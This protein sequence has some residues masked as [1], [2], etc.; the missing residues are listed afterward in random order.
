MKVVTSI[1]Q[2]LPATL[3][4]IASFALALVAEWGLLSVIVRAMAPNRRS[5]MKEPLESQRLYR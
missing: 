1:E 3:A 5:A 2:L 4:L